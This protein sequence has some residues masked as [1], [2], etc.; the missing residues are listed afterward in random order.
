[1]SLALLGMLLVW[2]PIAGHNRSHIFW[3]HAP[4]LMCPVLSASEDTA[5]DCCRLAAEPRQRGAVAKPEIQHEAARFAV[6]AAKLG[7]VAATQRCLQSHGVTAKGE[8]YAGILAGP[9]NDPDGDVLSLLGADNPNDGYNWREDLLERGLAGRS[10]P[11]DSCLR[12]TRGRGIHA[13]VPD[14]PRCTSR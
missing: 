14:I 11:Y 9:W 13:G 4:M 6:P 8:R 2:A 7:L 1:M 5:D 10:F 3:P 12:W